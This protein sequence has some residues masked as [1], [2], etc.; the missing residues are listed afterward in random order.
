MNRHARMTLRELAAAVAAAFTLAGCSYVAPQPSVTPTAWECLEPS[1]TDIA[2]V[3][4][5]VAVATPGGRLTGVQSVPLG[6]GYTLVAAHESG[7]QGSGASTFTWSVDTVW[8]TNGEAIA[9]ASADWSGSMP[10]GDGAIPAEQA[11]AA[12]GFAL[13]CSKAAQG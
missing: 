5:L 3:Q 1:A 7:S 2:A 10:N 9:P 8:V 12:R 6:N 13:A 4:R 11:K